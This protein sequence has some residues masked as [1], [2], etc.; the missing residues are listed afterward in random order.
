[1]RN[2]A[3]RM[4]LTRRRLLGSAA[5]FGATGLLAACSG[6]ATQSFTP[7]VVPTQPPT[8]PPAIAPVATVT[9]A[10]VAT[11]APVATIAPA[12]PAAKPTAAPSPT[13]SGVAFKQMY[14]QDAQH[15]GRSP[16]A[17]PTQ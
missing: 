6:T 15:T 13:S 16:F 3:G 12:A 1:M 11:S 5:A 10:P 9:P 2:Y 14:Q 17:G 8:P 7:V 4:H